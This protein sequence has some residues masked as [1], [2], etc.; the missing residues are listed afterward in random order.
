MIAIQWEDV[1]GV[2]QTCAPYLIA[3]GVIWVIA[4]VVMI[5]CRKAAKSKKK[6]IR[7][8]SLIAMVLAL[9]VVANMICLGPM[10]ALI[11]LTMGSGQ[12][13]QKT[14]DEAIEVADQIAEEGMVLLEN[15]GIL[16]I[17]APSNINLFGWSSV[18]PTYGGTG[19]GGLNELYEKISL[20]D[21]MEDAGFTVNQDLVDFYNEFS[22][23][24][25]EM[26]LATQNWTLTE[27]PV[28][29]YSDELIQG[30]KEFS[31]TAVI[32][33]SRIAGEG[34]ND[35]PG[36]VTKASYDN[37][38]NGYKD[39]EPG[40]HYLQ[41]SQTE[42]DMV[43]MV[44]SN[45]DNVILV[46]NA[47]N[48]M[49]LGFIDQYDQIRAAVWCQGP[50]HTGFEA[51][52][53]ILTGEV[54]PSGKTTD[55]FIYDMTAAP[56]WNNWENTHYSNMEDMAVEGMNSGMA[57]TYYP[58]FVNYVEGIYVGYKYYE[59]AAAEG[60]ID[61]DATVQ[62][63]FG[64]G[65]SYTTFTQKM[66]EIMESDGNISFDVTVTNTGSAAGKDV[67]E[68][69]YNPPYTNGGIEKA[70]ANLIRF[71]KTE[72]LEPGES[73]TISISFPAEELASYDMSGE[74]CYVLESGDY[75]ISINSDS[76]T[77]L[78][79]QTY[80]MDETIR[81]EGDNKRDS[82]QVTATNQF[83]DAAGDV[84]YL[85]RAD[86][87]ANYEEATAAPAS[88]VMS[89]DLVAQYH[90]NSN[91]DYSTYINEDD[92][93]PVTGADNG[94]TLADY[95]GVDYNDK[96]WDDLL[97]QLTVDDMSNM[98]A[99]SGYQTPAMD[100][101]GKVATVDADGPAA[102]N[103]NFTG[104][105]SIGFPVEVMIAC[106][107][108]QEL[109]QQYGEMMGKMC[110]EMNIAGWYAPG[111][112]THRTPFGARNYEYFSEDGTL[113][114]YIS[115]AAVQGAA[116][117]GVY[118]YIKHFALYE[119]NAKMVCV[120]S[121]EQAIREIYL[122]PFE[123]SV[124]VGDAHAVMVS[125]SFIGIKWS[126]ENSSLLNTVLRDEWGFQG[127][128]LTDF[129]RNNGHGFM[130]ADAGLANGVDAMLSTYAGG[131]NV[132]QNPD[133]ASSVKYMRQ[134]CKNVM[135]TVV[136]SWMYEDDGVSTS[137]PVWQKAVIGA[138]VVVG[139]ILVALGVLV[140][141][142]YKRRAV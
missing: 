48:P 106:T 110:R 14:T 70:A 7:G 119:M 68:V 9:A 139:V 62:Y 63:P 41:L 87:F 109:A 91:F 37:E 120:W 33:L 131:P 118:A 90:L 67:V 36:D 101:V 66:S 130:N 99:L 89:D 75:I 31:D 94:L 77:I 108:N 138:D 116:E 95:R 64:Y 86:G 44:C 57:Q 129:F 141:R 47:A 82:D 78:D 45:F 97:D 85:S 98:I 140:W 115:A 16:P 42:E 19:S 20:I 28:S 65:L 13:S 92:E 124:K 10:S 58:S 1:I 23:E 29:S 8:Y 137:M 112:N 111:M 107:W 73:E 35:M 6:M 40:E 25:A 52:G 30:A 18:N 121:N 54:N 79:Q 96:S 113:A 127:F 128:T 123:I 102:I 2:L 27:P 74:G 100:S 122:K 17:S 55:T 32:V 46:Y 142:K 135:Y 117:Q 22:T 88:D 76:H 134:A 126:G 125:W 15:D 56:W 43:D 26:S 133:A 24:R 132:V 50:G 53:K 38:L 21:S 136:N 3:L 39:F 84:T 11:N 93:M 114:G 51:L 60:V 61:Y 34:H 81:Y 105:G 69:Y 80:H 103:N 72:M 59:T 71:D 5:A 4:V 83:Q 49:E 104:A 12:V